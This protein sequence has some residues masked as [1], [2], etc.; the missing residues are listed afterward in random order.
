MTK[1]DEPAFQFHGYLKEH[2]GRGPYEFTGLTKREYF[3][4]MVLS[5]IESSMSNPKYM[6]SVEAVAKAHKKT[7]D[8]VMAIIAIGRADA[9]IA[10]LE[11]SK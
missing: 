5:G 7:P 10:E 2:G 9:L 6:A 11:K 3:A 1:A 4:A 8:E